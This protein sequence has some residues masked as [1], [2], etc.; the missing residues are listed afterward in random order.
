MSL[1]IVRHGRFWAVYHGT[2]LVVVTVYKKG[3]R[4]VQR[5]LTLALALAAGVAG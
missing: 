1:R 4:E 2:D 5:R 3:A